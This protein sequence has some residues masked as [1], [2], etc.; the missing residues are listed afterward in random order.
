MKIGY[1]EKWVDYSAVKITRDDYLGNVMRSD[2]F[3]VSRRLAR[4]GKPVDRA[5]WGMTPPTV[6]AYYSPTMNEITAAKIPSPRRCPN[7]PLIRL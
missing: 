3:E 5:E 6:N 7:S 2:A 4:M 1:P